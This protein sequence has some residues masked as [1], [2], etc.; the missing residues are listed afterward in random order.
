MAITYTSFMKTIDDDKVA[1]AL[2]WLL[3]SIKSNTDIIE[4]AVDNSNIQSLSNVIKIID[5]DLQYTIYKD[6]TS[7]IINHY[8]LYKYLLSISN[9]DNGE[10]NMPK[11]STAI[12]GW[13]FVR[14][15]YDYRG[16]TTIYNSNPNVTITISSMSLAND[17][18][19]FCNIPYTYDNVHR[20]YRICYY[21]VNALDF[22]GKIYENS[23]YRTRCPNKY[24]GYVKLL[25]FRSFKM[26]KCLIFRTDDRAILP[27]KTNLSDAGYDLTIIKEVKK[28]N[29]LVT[30]YDTGIKIQLDI[31]YYGEIVP[32]S[33][34][35]KSGY[36]LANSVG[37]IDV[38]YTGNIYIALL[39]VDQ[40][41][42]DIE[43]PFRCCQ[44]LIKKQI[45]AH[46]IEVYED[47]DKT[48][49]DIGGFG[50]TS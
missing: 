26:P 23:T 21:R 4:L 40:S 7:C 11:F 30:L 48:V 36:I 14:G 43:L 37:I 13:A 41:V 19:R 35:S 5:R 20:M 29:Q 38:G 24:T 12:Y 34:L 44:L 49:R 10:L 25:K 2:G 42:P 45:H 1:Y 27:V 28:W 8:K 47:F 6:C 22:I 39:K 17:I 15:C 46:M 50:S 31:G 18:V 16:N 33:S 32:R 3:L 9:F